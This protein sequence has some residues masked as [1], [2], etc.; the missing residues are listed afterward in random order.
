MIEFAALEV[1]N[2]EIVRYLIL[3]A[4]GAAA[5]TINTLAGGGSFLTLPILIFL[6]LPAT[7]ANGTNR[8]AV[9]LQNV[10]AVWGFHRH[11]V[12]P[13]SWAPWVVVPAIVGSILGTW[14]ALVV[15]DD[16][17]RRIL[18]LCMVV[19]SL[20]TLWDPLK[21]YR[22]QA[23]ERDDDG[24]WPPLPELQRREQV[25]LLVSFFGVGL[26]GGLVQAG[27]GLLIL[28][29]LTYV[30]VDLVRGNALK[31]LVILLF[32]AVSLGIFAWQ[33]QVDWFTGLILA[34]GSV[35]GSQI[36]VHLAVYK[37]HKWLKRVVTI[38]ILVFAIK[39]WVAP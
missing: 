33:D 21:K 34:A 29:A 1:W 37:G 28:A 9:S 12:L 5:G 31:A 16:A 8:V 3:F 14:A 39:L 7:L 6:G 11:R 4:A 17:F 32:T 38:T 24:N 36:G 26:Y 25:L 20:W 19:L 22:R 15:S 35:A 2:S 27:V 13:W 30:G 10:G 18:A 23:A